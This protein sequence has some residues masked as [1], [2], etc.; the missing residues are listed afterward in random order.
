MK[1]NFKIYPMKNVLVIL[2]VIL[3][4]ASMSAQGIYGG[5]VSIGKVLAGEETTYVGQPFDFIE[6]QVTYEGSSSVKNIGAFYQ[7]KF[8]WL[9]MRTDLG[10]TA[11][12]QRYQ[13]ESFVPVENP[14]DFAIDRFQFIDLQVMGGLTKDNWRFGAGPVAHILVGS[15]SE[16]DFIEG[17]QSK[18][19]GI[20]YGFSGGVGYDAGRL[21]LD[22]RYEVAFRNVGDH[23]YY[24]N[25]MARSLNKAHQINFTIG[26]S[27]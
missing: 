26:V 12:D 2:A 17:F 22:V 24:V 10:F 20:T 25:R 21:H 13:V 18:M 9:Y 3:S 7:H 23:L 15:D 8:G 5:K 11:V 14:L 19:R 1:L 27:I 4:A 6:H 16:L